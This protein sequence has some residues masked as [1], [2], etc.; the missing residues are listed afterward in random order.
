MSRW[1]NTAGH[2]SP[3]DHYLLPTTRRLPQV[4]G[5]IDQKS[6]FS[7]HAPRQVGKT[8]SLLTLAGELTAEGRYV[9][10]LVSME[11][12]AGFPSD[13]GA[14][15][16]AILRSWRAAASAQLPRQLEPPPW[17]DVEPGARLG[18]ALQAWAEAA[19]RPLVI[20]MDE[21]DALRNDVLI[22]VLRQLRDGYRNR[23]RGF[24]WSLALIGLSDVAKVTAQ[25]RDALGTSSPFN[26]QVESI[27]LRH[28]NEE[29]VAELYRQHTEE[30][31]QGF[32][33]SAVARV[34]ALTQGQ[35]WLVNALARQLV[36][37]MAGS[38][39]RPITADDVDRAKE[40]LITRRD[41]HLESLGER[42]EDPRI[43]WVIEPM[44][45]GQSL[46][47]APNDALRF[48]MDLGFVRLAPGGGLQI[49]N[50]IY[51]E[52]ILRHLAFPSRASLP[53]IPP[54]WLDAEGRLVKEPL[55]GAFLVFWRRHG[56]TLQRT[57]HYHQIAPHLVLMA[58]LERVVE[59]K[60]SLER[61]VEIGSG[62]M[63]VCVRHGAEV[64][65]IDLRVWQDGEDDPVT[66]GLMDID[67]YLER[68]DVAQGWL[69]IFDRRAGLPRLADRTE[70]QAQR[71]PGGR[72]VMVVRA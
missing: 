26:I 55:L 31:G 20:F 44:L 42:L 40:A 23:P 68:L 21:I 19:P 9:A 41:A 22:S 3:A 52:V 58:F 65:G 57:A 50:P 46:G 15:E 51:R 71:T 69:V 30:M 12:G 66:E 59:G 10:A 60:G 17:P 64:L 45:A 25:D 2:C 47:E 54:S 32:A 62:R 63:E 34:F 13:V 8:T 48:T 4:R 5:L 39:G 61:E 35:P 29:E 37:L 27:K 43:R 16:L 38:R 72:E 7:L 53:S 49:T 28:F 14:A 67:P 56:E 11:V 18:T 24:P 70:A 1:F 33:P 36:E 6:Y